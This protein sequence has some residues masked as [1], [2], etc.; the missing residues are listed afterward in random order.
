L[1]NR[2]R[3][4]A[5]LRYVETSEIK[6]EKRQCLTGNIVALRL[7]PE[8]V[9]SS[10]FAL[11]PRIGKD[12]DRDFSAG[13]ELPPRK[14]RAFAPDMDGLTSDPRSW[15]EPLSYVDLLTDPSVRTR[16]AKLIVHSALKRPRRGGR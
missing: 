10:E 12:P 5:A 3:R 2:V 9:F 11:M 16:V 14:G 13:Y 6:K 4:K 7:F 1:I 15:G 8:R